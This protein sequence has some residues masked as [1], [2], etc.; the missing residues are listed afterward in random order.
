MKRVY[1]STSRPNVIAAKRFA[2]AVRAVGHRVFSRWHD[3]PEQELHGE[4]SLSLEKRLAIG[5]G[6]RRDLM[7]SNVLVLLVHPACRGTLVEFGMAYN[8]GHTIFVVGDRRAIST[9]VE[10]DGVDYVESEDDVIK[11]L[12]KQE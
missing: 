12:K 9:M 7:D 5:N 1:V 10:Q 3:L 2:L 4:E 6:N 8:A 11:W